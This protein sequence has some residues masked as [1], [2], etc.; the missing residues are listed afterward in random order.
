M[1]QRGKEPL[2]GGVGWKHARQRGGTWKSVT[3]YRFFPPS[4]YS[5]SRAIQQIQHS[6]WVKPSA[7]GGYRK[8]TRKKSRWYQK[9]YCPT[10]YCS[11]ELGLDY[12]AGIGHL[13]KGFNL[14]RF[15]LGKFPEKQFGGKECVWL[16]AGDSQETIVWWQIP[17]ANRGSVG[18]MGRW[19]S[20]PPVGF[21]GFGIDSLWG[22]KVKSRLDPRFWSGD[23]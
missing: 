19:I 2:G 23:W 4:L 18:G 11:K 13:L 10:W 16:D 8:N 22:G 9:V 21:L 17:K 3:G 15:E 12:V 6:G 20:R 7:S 1:S 5:Q 14:S